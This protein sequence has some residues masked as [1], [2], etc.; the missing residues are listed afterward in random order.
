MLNC[1]AASIVLIY[2]VQNNIKIFINNKFIIPRSTLVTSVQT[3]YPNYTLANGLKYKRSH[4][5][6]SSADRYRVRSHSTYVV[7]CLNTVLKYSPQNYV[8]YT[9]RKLGVQLTQ[10]LHQKWR[11]LKKIPGAT[12]NRK[13]TCKEGVLFHFV[14]LEIAPNIVRV[15]KSRR[16]RWAGHV[17]R[18]GE[19]RI[20]LVIQTVPQ[21][22]AGLFTTE[23]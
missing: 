9:I 15:I 17:A 12:S 19:E 18:M 11:K 6:I 2:E 5:G 16:M 21:T 23:V 3:T 20:T 7:I 4:A 22:T 8:S 14:L 13:R 1:R 10:K